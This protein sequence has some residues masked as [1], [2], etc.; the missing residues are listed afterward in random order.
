[1]GS[2]GVS[3]TALPSLTVAGNTV[4]SDPTVPADRGFVAWNTPPQ[5]AASSALLSL[6]GAAG[7]L[8]LVRIRRVPATTITNLLIMVAT[9]GSGL[10]A[11]QCFGALY[12]AAGALVAQTVDQAAAWAS[13]GLKTMA[14]SSPQAV[15]AGDYYVGL[16]YNGTT[17]PAVV[18]SNASINGVT[19]N[20]GLAA[21]NFE[22]C[23]TNDTG[24]TT[25]APATFGTQTAQS[26]YW[27]AGLS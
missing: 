26:L 25:T 6:A 3:R 20:A 27:W 13:L 9:A 24:L 19:T 18:R 4:Y 8:H 22:V 2:S 23:V 17:A 21:P 14:L 11:G 12:T 1:M 15:A 7:V 10:T 5:V 16:W